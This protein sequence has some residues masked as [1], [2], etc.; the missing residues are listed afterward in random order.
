MTPVQL[1]P[2]TSRSN[3]PSTTWLNMS[4]L[5][6]DQKFGEL[7][8]TGPVKFTAGV[9]SEEDV[10]SSTAANGCFTSSAY[11]KTSLSKLPGYRKAAASAKASTPPRYP[12]LEPFDSPEFPLLA[13]RS[14]HASKKG[15]PLI[16]AYPIPVRRPASESAGVAARSAL[17]IRLP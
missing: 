11:A 7:T 10:S 17:E 5:S 2:Q 13:M 15:A 1:P 12:L 4:F 6:V 3:S 9:D 16:P 8:M 14:P